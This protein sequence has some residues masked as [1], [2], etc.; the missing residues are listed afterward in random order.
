[1]I[2]SCEKKTIEEDF[3]NT[4]IVH[5]RNSKIM[6]RELGYKLITHMSQIPSALNERWDH[7]VCIYASPY[8]KYKAYM[9]IL[10]KNPQAKLWW[11]QNDHD[12]EDNILLRNY[13]KQFHKPYSMICNNPRSGYRHW[14]LGKNLE[15]KKLNDWI[16]QWHTVNL[17]AL[18]YNDVERPA[19]PELKS[20][21]LYFGTFRKH[22]AKDMALFNGIRDYTISSSTKNQKKYE[23]AGIQANFIDKLD[24]TEGRETLNA[25]KYS[26][27][28]EDIHTHTNY[29]YLANRFY[30]CLMCNVIMFFDAKCRN[31][32]DEARKSGYHIHDAFIVSTPEE[33]NQKMS[34]ID[35]KPEAY[36]WA[37]KQQQR[38]K[39]VAQR[40]KSEALQQI[41]QILS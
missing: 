23:E 19:I 26:I 20:G 21:C 6:E 24:W 29:A 4:S 38:N 13:I 18:I 17:N 9:E 33:L 35:A 32:I 28:F 41:K 12:N 31:T 37:L 11:H 16:D 36:E 15:G 8:M 5:V 27:Y 1:M 7:I 22:R 3:S 25:Y 30:E 39:S 14:I 34:T 40:D 2:E 10:E